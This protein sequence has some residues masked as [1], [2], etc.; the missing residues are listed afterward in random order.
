ML[1]SLPVDLGNGTLSQANLEELW[2]ADRQALLDCY[3][4]HLALRNFV[5]DRDDALRGP[6]VPTARPK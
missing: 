6:P 2:I 1:C 4:R 5:T 3:R